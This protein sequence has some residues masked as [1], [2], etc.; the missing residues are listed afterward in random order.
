[1]CPLTY[2][3]LGDIGRSSMGVIPDYELHIERKLA[4]YLENISM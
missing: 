1:M 2:D 4:G 3:V